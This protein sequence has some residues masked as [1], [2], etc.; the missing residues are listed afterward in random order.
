[1]HY[2]VIITAEIK[3]DVFKPSGDMAAERL[4]STIFG[5]STKVISEGTLSSAKDGRITLKFQSTN[6]R[7]NEISFA[8]SEPGLI[9]F[10]RGETSHQDP[11]TVF[12]EEGKRHRCISKGHGG[13]RVE[14]TTRTDHLENRLLKSGK[15]VLE[16][17]IEVCGVRV[18]YTTIKLSVVHD[19]SK[20]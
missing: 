6:N 5:S 19:K 13:E 17:S 9:S 10:R 2:D 11:V 18:E 12:L 7:E 4:L 15:M 1:M 8:K 16:Y 20:E 14:F 3:Q